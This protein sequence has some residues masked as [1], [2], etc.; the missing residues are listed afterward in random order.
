V[1]PAILGP[2]GHLVMVLVQNRDISSSFLKVFCF[3]VAMLFIPP[4]FLF[5]L[6]LTL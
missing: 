3:K 5:V 4:T 1:Y 2:C 6:V